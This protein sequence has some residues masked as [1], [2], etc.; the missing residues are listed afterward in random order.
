MGPRPPRLAH[1]V[2]RD[3]HGHPQGVPRHPRRRGGPA[4]PAPR[5]RDGAV[6]GLPRPAAV[7]QLL[8]A[9]GAPQH[10]GPEDVQVSQE[11][12]HDPPG[13][14]GAHLSAA[15]AHVP[16]AAVGQEHEL[17]R[18][19]HRDGEGGGAEAEALLRQAEVPPPRPAQQGLAGR[20]REG[21]GRGAEGLRG[22][23]GGVLAG[24][25]HHRQGRGVPLEARL[26]VP[27]VLRRPA[28]RGPGAGEQGGGV[29]RA[30]L[31]H[32]GRRGPRPQGG[33]RGRLDPSAGR[34]CRPQAGRAPA[35]AR[36]GARRGRHKRG[37]RALRPR[38]RAGGEGGSGGLRGGL[39]HLPDRHPG[40]G[41]GGQARGRAVAP[42]RRGPRQGFRGAG[43]AAGGPRRWLPLDVR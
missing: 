27:A 9:R 33:Q 2:L 21:L 25:L 32:P 18:P 15:A 26:R 30:H 7:G 36:Q 35:R 28:G 1:R 24:Q 16:H 37:R 3:G 38:R 31:R 40:H 14:A 6:G 23:S 29:R 42:L 17:L 8:L 39:R 5:Q 43:R 12:H 10:R 34:V 20:P 13:S 41:E 22:R 11:L 19:G 4:L